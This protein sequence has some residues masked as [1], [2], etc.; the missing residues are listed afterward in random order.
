MRCS[1]GHENAPDRQRCAACGEPLGRRGHAWWVWLLVFL[2]M[3]ALAVIEYG[4]KRLRDPGEVPT[5]QD[6]GR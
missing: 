1:C 6:A 5:A 2:G 4:V 3:V